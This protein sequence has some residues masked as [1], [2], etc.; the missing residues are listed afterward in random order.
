MRIR[1]TKYSCNWL[2]KEAL[3]TACERLIPGNTMISCLCWCTM[4]SRHEVLF[5]KENL[6]EKRD[7]LA[8]EYIDV[9]FTEVQFDWLTAAKVNAS[10]IEVL[11]DGISLCINVDQHAEEL[12]CGLS[13]NIGSKNPHL[14]ECKAKKMMTKRGY[15]VI[16]ITPYTPEFP[17]IENVLGA[18]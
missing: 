1:T 9:P 18:R 16:W 11:V 7:W 2:I 5:S 4:S 17:Q 12:N 15:I 10:G 6:I 3:K 14:L 8:C 13:V